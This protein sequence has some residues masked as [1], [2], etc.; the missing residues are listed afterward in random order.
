M[1]VVSSPRVRHARNTTKGSPRKVLLV[2]SA[3]PDASRVRSEARRA[4][5]RGASPSIESSGMAVTRPT[6]NAAVHGT[7][8]TPASTA[9]RATGHAVQPSSTRGAPSTVSRAVPTVPLRA[10][11]SMRPPADATP[12]P[13]VSPTVSSLA[14]GR[15]SDPAIR[16]PSTVGSTTKAP[17]PASHPLLETDVATLSAWREP[18]ADDAD[19]GFEV[20]GRFSHATSVNNATHPAITRTGR[21]ESRRL[22]NRKRRRDVMRRTGQRGYTRG[23]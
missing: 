14:S 3:N 19:S 10:N 5:S 21:R 16:P 20:D 1:K 8:A 18:P 22:P 12:T 6:T 2:S 11:S 9:R 15:N 7:T 4:E 13:A 23:L 17:A